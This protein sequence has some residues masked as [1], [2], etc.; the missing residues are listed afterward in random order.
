MLRRPAAD[1]RVGPGGQLDQADPGVGGLVDAETGLAQ[2]EIHQV[3][4]VGVVLDDHHDPRGRSSSP[5][6]WSRTRAR[7]RLMHAAMMEA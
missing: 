5:R 3:G 4:D 7:I 1:R 6:P 2:V